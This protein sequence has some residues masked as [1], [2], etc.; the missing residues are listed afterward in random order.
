MTEAETV[1]GGRN[2]T[3]APVASLWVDLKPS[4]V[5]EASE[6]GGPPGLTETARAEAR[7]LSAAGRG[8][9]LD[10]GGPAWRVTAVTRNSP[11]VGRMTLHLE[12]RWS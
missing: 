4:G 5:R 1:F 8:Q 2:R 6:L 9:R 12:R 7:S 11:R 3:W 10:A